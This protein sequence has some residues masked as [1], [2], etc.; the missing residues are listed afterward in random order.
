M[1]GSD[2]GDETSNA[3]ALLM[4]KCHQRGSIAQRNSGIDGVA[5]AELAAGSEVDGEVH[6]RARKRYEAVAR[7]SKGDSTSLIAT[8]ESPCLRAAVPATSGRSKSGAMTGSPAL[9]TCSRK[10][11]L[12][13]WKISSGLKALT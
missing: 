1:L 13:P 12:M 6:D 11:M 3:F 4:V 2:R 10:R 5:T 8:R 9:A 7:Q